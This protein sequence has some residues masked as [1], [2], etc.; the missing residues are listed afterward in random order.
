MAVRGID[1]REEKKSY[2]SLFV[3]GSAVLVVLTL[4]SF[5]DDNITRRPW[6]RYQRQFYKLDYQKA[7]AAYNEEDKK[8]QAD[9]AYQELSKKVAAA[10]ESLAQGELKKQLDA[11]NRQET[12]AKVRFTELDQDI[13]FIKS[14]LEEAWYDHDYA[15]Q[16]GGNTKP[17]LARI[18]ELNKE[19]AKLD[20]QFEAARQKRDQLKDQIEKLQSGVKALEDQ[21]AKMAAERDKWIR[22]M[23][24]A[25]STVR[26]SETK[27]FSFY[28]IP[29]SNRSCCRSLIATISTNP[30]RAWTAARVVTSRSTG[31]A[32]KKSRSHFAPTRTAKF[33]SRTMPIR[34]KSSVA[35]LAMK[36]RGRPSTAS[37]R[38][39]A[40]CPTGKRRSSGGP[41]FRVAVFRAI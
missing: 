41:R 30:W 16:T 2:G 20:P 35:R 29:A 25:T 6:K 33:C 40:R 9:P 27:L 21:L 14:E 12:D 28:K 15:V 5:W 3:L 22:V 39:T 18:E 13:K 32:S 17:A 23:E 26:I 34:L 36:A 31:P 1:E 11:L 7:K 24:N 38:R 4:W 10:R 19:K 37:S 8:L